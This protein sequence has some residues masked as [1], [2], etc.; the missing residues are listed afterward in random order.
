MVVVF[1]V[2]PSEVGLRLFSL[3]ASNEC[4]FSLSLNS[5]LKLLLVLWSDTDD[6]KSCKPTETSQ[7]LFIWFCRSLRMLWYNKSIV[8]GWIGT[9]PLAVFVDTS[10]SFAHGYCNIIQAKTN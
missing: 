2:S 1:F 8:R 10:N 7:A 9:Y 5:V 3:G 6:Y 4:E